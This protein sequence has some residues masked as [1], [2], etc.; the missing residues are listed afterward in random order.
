M[1]RYSAGA[2]LAGV[3]YVHRISDLKFGGL[4][5]KNFRMFR[6]LCGEK[7]LENVIVVTN[8]W[9][10]VT[11]QQGDARERQLKNEHFKAAVEKGAQLRRHDNTPESAQAIL[12][13]II[14]NQP[15]VLKIQHELIDE[16]KNIEETGAGAEL[17][18]EIR[19]VVEKYQ[20]E[21]RELED[22]MRSVIGMDEEYRKELEDEKKRM[23]EEIEKLR[24]DSEG[25]RSGFEVARR[26]VEERI[27]ARFEEQTMRVQEG[28]ATKIHEYEDK[29]AELERNK[30][31]NM[32]EIEDLKKS[33]GEL[34][35]E[36]R[37]IAAEVKTR[38]CIIM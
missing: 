3:I 26:E 28:Y 22:S 19:E 8:M 20:R 21:I 5:V 25:M 29:L 17:T 12:R 32:S 14:K 37:R 34:Y 13:E 24:K 16:G 23:E 7:T 11:P 9:G 31:D 33:L 18:R 2:K 38:R 35:Q 6:E 15:V 27:S 4:A 36:V 10:Q 1:F 30:G